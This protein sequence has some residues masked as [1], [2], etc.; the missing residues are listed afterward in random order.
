MSSNTKFL[1]IDP[2]RTNTLLTTKHSKY[3]LVDSIRLFVPKPLISVILSLSGGDKV[4]TNFLLTNIFRD[5]I[6]Y[7]YNL[8]L[9]RCQYIAQWEKLNNISLPAKTQKRNPLPKS[10]H[11]TEGKGELEHFINTFINLS[12]EHYLSNVDTIFSYIFNFCFIFDV[13]GGDMAET[14]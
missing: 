1:E 4:L 13:S 11:Y 12:I 7:L 3:S 8:W 10:V 5:I 2:N 9:S 14:Y 6:K